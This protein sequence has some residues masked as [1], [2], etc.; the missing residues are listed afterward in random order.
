MSSTVT[1]KVSVSPCNTMPSES[2]TNKTGIS[3]L[4]NN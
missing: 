3:W 1:G 4:S 2:P